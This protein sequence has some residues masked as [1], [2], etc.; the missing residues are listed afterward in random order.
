S[1]AGARVCCV[2]FRYRSPLTRPEPTRQDDSKETA[3]G[4]RTVITFGTYDVFHVG[5]VR[6]LRRARELGDR[7]VV[8]ISS[9]ALNIS[10]K[11]RPPVYTQAERTEIVASLR[12]VD[13]VFIEE[14]LDLKR[15]Y[16][17]EHEADILTMGDDWK[18]RF[19]DM[20]DICKVVYFPRTP[21]VSTTALIEHISNSQ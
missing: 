11:G 18:G 3:V 7:L 20:G 5:H 6:L 13:D 12:D 9:D 1:R 16:I 15:E 19:D 17:L 14:S 21:S 10:K 8:G 4:E 2:P